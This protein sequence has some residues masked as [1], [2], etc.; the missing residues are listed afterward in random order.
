MK[1]RNFKEQGVTLVALVISI[2]VLII[3][4]VVT[5]N[6][7]VGNNG[8]I[9]RSFEARYMM[10]LS[11]FQEELGSFKAVKLMDNDEFSESSVTAG[12]NSLIYNTQPEEE[13]GNIYDVITSL[14]DSNFAGKLEIIKGEI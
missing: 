10:Q 4:S 3:L 13:G 6:L 7:T 8:I 5:F 9:T 11:S 12:E 2:I 1:K 14:K